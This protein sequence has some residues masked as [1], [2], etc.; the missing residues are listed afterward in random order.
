MCSRFCQKKVANGK[1]AAENVQ[2]EVGKCQICLAS[3]LTSPCKLVEVCKFAHQFAHFC[4]LFFEKETAELL[5]RSNN[6]KNR[7]KCKLSRN[8]RRDGDRYIHQG[9]HELLWIRRLYNYW[10]KKLNVS[11]SKWWPL[12]NPGLSSLLVGHRKLPE[13]L[14]IFVPKTHTQRTN[15]R[16]FHRK[17]P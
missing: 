17:F 15:K 13:R 1:Y 8:R 10:K 9:K 6:S 16:D 4:N 12:K 5:P 7:K 11:T 3:W 14:N 2:A